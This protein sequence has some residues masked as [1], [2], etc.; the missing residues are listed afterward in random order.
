MYD[1]FEQSPYKNGRWIAPHNSEDIQNFYFRARTQFDLSDRLE[2]A[3]L[4]L[5][6]DSYYLLFVN[7][8]EVSRGPA[9]GTH[10]HNYY[11]SLDVATYLRPGRNV[12]A[13]L[14][15]CMNYDTF[16]A[17]PVQPG[18]IAEIDGVVATDASWEVSI[19]NDWRRDVESY[20]I[21]V[22][23]SE[24]RDMRLEPL[25]WTLADDSVAWEPAWVIPLSS[26][27]YAKKLLPRSI[28]ALIER[29][30][31]PVDIPVVASV[32]EVA[33]L[34]AVEISEWMLQEAYS[35]PSES[36]ITGLATVL[37]G[38]EG[39]AR[40]EP[41]PDGSGITII[42]NFEA[43]IAGRFKLELT[44]P[45]GTVV[46]VCYNESVKDE[47]LAIKHSQ[48]SYHFVDRYV[49]REGRQTIGSSVYD[50]GFKM[51]QIVLRNF[52]STVE[53]HK[54]SAIENRYPFVKRGSFHCDDML[55]N[56]IWDVC[57]ETLEACTTDVFTDCPWRERAYWVN[58]LIVENKTSLQ[59]FGASEVHR[60][61]FRMAFSEVRE[62]ELFAGVC[63]CPDGYDHLVLVPTNLF[64]VLML[65]DYLMHS[66]D[67]QLIRE[68]L[69]KITIILETF[70]RWTDDRGLVSPDERYWN[71]FDWSY[72]L[73]DISLNGK[74]TSLLNYLYVMAMKSMLEM[75]EISAA[76]VDDTA[77]KL[78]ISKASINLEE[79]FFKQDEKLLSDW[80][81]DDGRSSHSSQLAHAF[82]LLSGETSVDNRKYF[83]D[84]LSD[85]DILIPELYLHYFVFQAMQMCGREAE[86]L[87]RIRK[88]WGNIVKTG[89]PT[90]WEA[91]IH[92]CGKEAFGGDGSLCHGFATC[93]IAFLQNVI[94][95]I[96]PLTP[97]FESFKVEPRSLGLN[98]AE[99]RIP[100]PH[101]NIYIRWVSEG[102]HLNVEL[103]V[104]RGTIAHV[105]SGSRYGEG[106]HFFKIKINSMPGGVIDCQNIDT[107]SQAV[108]VR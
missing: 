1:A 4:H 105:S 7:G 42:F 85:T 61:A 58:D 9:R 53:I 90:I 12:I 65:K 83:E 40:I 55:L 74:T 38:Q 29:I 56:R 59:A 87:G 21:Q 23:H 102:A 35:T 82:A 52:G 103:K 88:Y 41:A 77:Y 91:G 89:S 30:I 81:D 6:A 37:S 43:E 24:W 75:A 47:R 49:L 33:D 27:L 5:C 54:V 86:A 96:E 15:Q 84:A 100:T 14:V 10:T 70:S 80:I 78:R 72:E 101:G 57:C 48:D 16:V 63:P 8:L 34:C 62:G 39:N 17:A 44:A 46:D 20:S 92:E 71:F 3:V 79:C 31:F 68:L 28:P 67:K 66:G 50:R 11:D 69:P 25:G 51:V 98:S 94:L 19:G 60:R 26:Q 93:P 32:P 97:G 104:P 107:V 108:G 2:R 18:L 76:K 95:G 99:G 13:V 73:N 106:R 64:V 36:R 22:G 45:E